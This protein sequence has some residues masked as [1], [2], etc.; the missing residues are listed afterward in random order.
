[1]NL[2]GHLIRNIIEILIN[3]IEPIYKSSPKAETFTKFY[4][5]A[6]HH[7]IHL[8]VPYSTVSRALQ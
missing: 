1:M 8:T 5:A 3:K 6:L 7:S 4:V 2:F